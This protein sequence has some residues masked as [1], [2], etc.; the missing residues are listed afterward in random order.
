MKAEV[1][2]EAEQCSV[3]MEVSQS[4]EDTF[5]QS[6]IMTAHE[7]IQSVKKSSSKLL[8][9]GLLAVLDKA[10]SMLQMIQ[11]TFT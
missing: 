4:D 8:S 1:T 11:M 10:L 3:N 6:V 2:G 7:R 5:V 9:R